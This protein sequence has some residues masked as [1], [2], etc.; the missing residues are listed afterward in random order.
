MICKSCESN[1]LSYYAGEVAMRAPGLKNIDNP[2][3]LVFPEF[4][5]CLDCGNVEFAVNG[6]ELR[7][8]AQHRTI[9]LDIPRHCVS[10]NSHMP[11]QAK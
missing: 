9:P 11:D 10:L 1:N 8:L 4:I 3:V 7:L 5:V 6:A 2:P